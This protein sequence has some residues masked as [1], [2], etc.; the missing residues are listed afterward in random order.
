MLDSWLSA[1]R[2]P[3][4]EKNNSRGSQDE[5][6]AETA[7]RTVGMSGDAEGMFL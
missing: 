6:T 1:D 5:A 2:L 4:A 3:P 7:E